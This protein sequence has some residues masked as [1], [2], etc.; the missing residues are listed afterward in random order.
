MDFL[1]KCDLEQ[2]KKIQKLKPKEGQWAQ[3]R[4]E[5]GDVWHEI[6]MVFDNS[7][8]LYCHRRN[9]RR[10]SE[11]TF[12]SRIRKVVKTLPKNARVVACKEGYFSER[13]KNLSQI[14]QRIK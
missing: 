9:E 12:F 4:T 8:M 11:Y 3:L 1:E 2:T 14:P 6:E 10:I 13:N 5:Y 7:M